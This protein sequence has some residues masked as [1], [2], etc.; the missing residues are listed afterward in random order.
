M[1]KI[2]LIVILFFLFSLNVEAKRICH[3]GTENVVDVRCDI[4]DDY[5]QQCY[6]ETD[7]TALA[8]SNA[9]DIL[10]WDKAMYG[11][12]VAKDW[13]QENDACPEYLVVRLGSGLN[14]YRL[15]AY[16]SYDEANSVL[17]DFN[18]Q[19][20]HLA[21]LYNE[22]TLSRDEGTEEEDAPNYNIDDTSI[23]DVCNMPEYRKT[24]KF[25]GTIVSFAKI[26][27]P[28]LIIAF[29]IV[30]LYKAITSS[31]DDRIFKAVRSIIIRVIAGVAIFLLPGIVQFV[32]NMVNEWS[33][34]E[35]SW[36]CCTDCLLNPDCD[37]NSCSSDSCRIEGMN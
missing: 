29:G 16:N 28:L 36:C 37:T 5:T 12:F 31:K 22:E 24:M 23:S 21:E 6:V 26:V 8:S 15:Y 2:G 34:Y 19:N 14:G 27:V 10:N 17:E 20:Y 9:E 7:G 4:F 30:D 13:V 35:N 33:E 25:F 18:S 3:Y 1:K 32:L 11:T